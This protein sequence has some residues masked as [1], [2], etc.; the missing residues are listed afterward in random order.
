MMTELFYECAV[1]A[2]VV[3]AL[4]A[5]IFV[6][7]RVIKCIVCREWH[8]WVWDV[9]DFLIDLFWTAVVGVLFGLIV[10][11]ICIPLSLIRSM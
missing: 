9:H 2:V 4:F 1:V 7:G 11:T 6:I 3:C 8:Y 10:C 5:F